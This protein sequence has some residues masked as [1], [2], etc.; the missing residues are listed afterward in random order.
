MTENKLTNKKPIIMINNKKNIQFLF[1][2][3]FSGIKSWI[4]LFTSD[5]VH[6]YDHYGMKVTNNIA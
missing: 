4:F 3:Y 2:F 5:I 1:F 6:F